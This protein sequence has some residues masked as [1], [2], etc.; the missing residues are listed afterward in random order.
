MGKETLC[1]GPK[2]A[3]VVGLGMFG[4]MCSKDKMTDGDLETT[5]TGKV[6]CVDF[7]KKPIPFHKMRNSSHNLAFDVFETYSFINNISHS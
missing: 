4:Y 2:R 7:P 5:S 1:S 6:W 3:Y